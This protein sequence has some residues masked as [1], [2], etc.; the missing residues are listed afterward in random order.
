MPLLWKKIF[1]NIANNSEY[2]FDYCNRPI[3]KFHRSCPEWYLYNKP[4]DNEIRMLND[5]LNTNYMLVDKF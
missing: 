2:V 1:V 5:K 4:C 3:N